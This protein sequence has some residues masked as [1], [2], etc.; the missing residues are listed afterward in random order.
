M[1][2]ILF[3]YCTNLW[4]GSSS[5]FGARG[6]DVIQLHTTGV[7]KY[8]KLGFNIYAQSLISMARLRPHLFFKLTNVQFEREKGWQLNS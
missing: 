1:N 8:S 5:F 7:E 6:G 4:Q 2:G 3:I